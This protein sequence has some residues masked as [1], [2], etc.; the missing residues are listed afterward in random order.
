M[1]DGRRKHHFVKSSHFLKNHQ[2]IQNIQNLL[3]PKRAIRFKMPMP[4]LSETKQLLPFRRRLVFCNQ[5][6]ITYPFET[7]DL[8]TDFANFII[9]SR[10]AGLA[11]S[12]RVEVSRA[13]GLAPFLRVEVSCCGR[14]S[15][16]GRSIFRLYQTNSMGLLF[17]SNG[18]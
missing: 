4:V 1:V 9:A 18:I 15:R 2:I 10:T 11:C 3:G 14:H 16:C 8:L 12:V 17:Y 5:I 13:A 6:V 7:D